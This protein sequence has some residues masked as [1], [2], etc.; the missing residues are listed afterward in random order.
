MQEQILSFL[1]DPFFLLLKMTLLLCS[2]VIIILIIN[3]LLPEFEKGTRILFFLIVL[4]TI[5][6]VVVK[7]FTLIDEIAQGLAHLFTAFYPILTSSFMLSSSITAIASWQPFL[8]FFVQVLTIISSKW[9]IPGVLLAIVFDVCSVIVK[10]ISFTR[11]ADL[12]RF[13]IMSIVSASV[14]CYVLLMTAGGVAAFSVNAAVA[15]PVK[16]LIEENIPVVGS[17]IVDSFS[18]FQHMTQF[19]SSFTSISAFIAVITVSFIP[20]IQLVV[21]AY[22]LKMLAAILEPIAFDDICR[23]LD[24]I[25]KSLF[26][27]CAVSFLIAFSFMFSCFFLI[28]FVQV[29]AGGR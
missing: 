18:M 3:M 1:I 26:T 4:A 23:L 29:M 6:P 24:Q 25:S 16:K 10:E 5:G 27:L 19:T 12:I 14:I 20:T 7:S 8:L 2:Y 11:I 22:S 28:V 17:F 9:L 21:S 15:E 13:T